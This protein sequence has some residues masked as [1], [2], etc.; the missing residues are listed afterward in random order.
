MTASADVHFGFCFGN[1][2]TIGSNAKYQMKYCAVQTLLN[3][4]KEIVV[5]KIVIESGH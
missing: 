4:T 1:M 3:M 5:K 2:I